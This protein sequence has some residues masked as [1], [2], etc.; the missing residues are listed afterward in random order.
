M[1]FKTLEREY[2]STWTLETWNIFLLKNF[3]AHSYMASME[4]Q[5]PLAASWPS[6]TLCSSGKALLLQLFLHRMGRITGVTWLLEYRLSAR[7]TGAFALISSLVHCNTL[8][9]D[10]HSTTVFSYLCLSILLQRLFSM[11]HCYHYILLTLH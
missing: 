7:R 9:S 6:Q 10:P 4:M 3:P 8:T 11:A 1:C 2:L 5:I